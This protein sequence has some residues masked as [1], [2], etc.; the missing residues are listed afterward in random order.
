[1]Q[2]YH[3]AGLR[4][5]EVKVYEGGRHEILNEINRDEVI[6]DILTWLNKKVQ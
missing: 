3:S 4:D 1:V 2:L 6:S 5:V